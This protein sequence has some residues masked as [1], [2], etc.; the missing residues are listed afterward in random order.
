MDPW[1]AAVRC[2]GNRVVLFVMAAFWLLATQHCN[3]EAA[4]LLAEHAPSEQNCCEGGEAHCVHDGCRSVEDLGFSVSNVTKAPLP[5]LTLC[6][7]WELMATTLVAAEAPSAWTDLAVERALDW[8]PT[9]QFVRRAACSP[10]APAI[11]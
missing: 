7:C 6:A 2:A 3:L 11:R 10:R 8:V 1:V 5:A 9:W 4:Q